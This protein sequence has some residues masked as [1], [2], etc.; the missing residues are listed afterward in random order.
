MNFNSCCLV[1]K[2]CVNLLW[3]HGWW[4][5]RLLCP[6]DFPGKNTGV[7]C[8][9]LL[10]GIFLTRRSNWS[11]LHWQADSLPVDHQGSLNFRS[12]YSVSKSC[13]TLCSFIDSNTPGFSA[14][15]YLPEF[16]Q[17]HVHWVSDAI[18]PSHPLLPSPPFAFN[19]SQHQG[20]F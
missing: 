17:T 10:K 18:Q 7:G 19:L 2:S 6:W 8:H 14:L 9:F 3:P 16:A 20:L 5:S 13:P 1:T 15:H 12:C 11:F 4:P